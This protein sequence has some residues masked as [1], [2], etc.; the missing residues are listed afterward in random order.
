ML[1]PSEVM[2]GKEQGPGPVFV[3]D[4]EE[5]FESVQSSVLG[6]ERVDCVL[7]PQVRFQDLCSSESWS[8]FMDHQI[9]RMQTSL[10]VWLNPASSHTHRSHTHKASGTAEGPRRP[11]PPPGS[12][13]SS[14][15]DPQIRT[16]LS[17][18]SPRMWIPPRLHGQELV[19]L[20][21]DH[22]ALPVSSQ[23]AKGSPGPRTACRIPK[24][25]LSACCSIFPL[26][27]AV[28]ES[29]QLQP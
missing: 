20:V 16:C 4:S 17:W 28:P 21:L 6:L 2:L 8:T 29:L 14:S 1:R 15:P 24:N 11:D 23:Q 10:K 5:N 27:Q 13:G 3:L 18:R 7:V 22:S 19:S 25:E 9:L 12:L 26:L